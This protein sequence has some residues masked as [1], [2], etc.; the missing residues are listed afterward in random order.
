V[1]RQRTTIYLDTGQIDA[2]DR[3]AAEAGVSRAEL[4][5]RVIDRALF[6]QHADMDEDLRAIEDMFGSA[7]VIE[8]IRRSTDRRARQLARL[9]N[10][11]ARSG[12][13]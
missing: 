1:R 7:D 10:A 6:G 12:R 3:I 8:P 9:A 4:I 2:L 13:C 11:R 5:R